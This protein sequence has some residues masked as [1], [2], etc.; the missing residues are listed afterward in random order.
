MRQKPNA[1]KI[2]E[3]LDGRITFTED[4]QEKYE[5][6]K[7]GYQSEI[8]ADKRFEKYGWLIIKSLTFHLDGEYACQIDTIIITGDYIFL[9]EIKWYSKKA[10]DR[11]K[12]IQYYSGDEDNPNGPEFKHPREQLKEATEKFK[13]LMWQLGIKKT[14]RTYVMFTHPDFVLYNMEEWSLDLVFHSEVE[15]HIEELASTTLRPDDE[16]YHIY[17]LLM[18]EN[19]DTSETMPSVPKYNYA[20]TRKVVKCPECNGVIEEVPKNRR[21]LKC[22][23]C[24]KLVLI[25]DIAKKALEDYEVLFKETPTPTQLY[26]WC[27]GIFNRMRL[28][29][30]FYSNKQKE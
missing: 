28:Y 18:A 13:R 6:F 14:L 26:N 1:L 2:F 8:W 7:K 16:S 29:K 21:K 23:C 27:G 12:T 24:G 22:P 9:Y 17:N 5:N 30:L 20:S 3:A 15:S 19:L 10:T 25:N 11:G 4:Q